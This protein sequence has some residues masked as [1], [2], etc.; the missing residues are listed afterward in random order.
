MTTE[1]NLIS[2]PAAEIVKRVVSVN[3]IVF[4]RMEHMSR[5]YSTLL[6]VTTGKEVLESLAQIMIGA[7]DLAEL[8][9]AILDKC[10]CP[11]SLVK[12]PTKFAGKT[13]DHLWNNAYHFYNRFMHAQS[14]EDKVKELTRLYYFLKEV[15]EVALIT[16]ADH[17]TTGVKRK[18]EAIEEF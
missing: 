1:S 8:I 5:A 2:T 17:Y 4:E 9:R 16:K 13:L 10:G 18:K 14:P 6:N 12:D 3:H 11:P 7:K 15:E